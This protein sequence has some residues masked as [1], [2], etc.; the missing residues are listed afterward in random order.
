MIL[1]MSNGVFPA[2]LLSILSSAGC[3]VYWFCYTA[4]HKKKEKD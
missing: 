4:K 3:V 1:G 2:W